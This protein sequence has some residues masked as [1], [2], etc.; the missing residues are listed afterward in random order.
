MLEFIKNFLEIIDQNVLSAVATLFSLAT[1]L[2]TTIPILVKTRKK[3]MDKELLR[4]I[5]EINKDLV[6]KGHDIVALPMR[7]TFEQF[8]TTSSVVWNSK[9]SLKIKL[10]STQK[11]EQK[12]KEKAVIIS[13]L[14]LSQKLKNIYKSYVALLIA[15]VIALFLPFIPTIASVLTIILTILVFLYQQVLGYRVKN[16][17]FGSNAYEAQELLEFLVKNQDK[18]DGN[19]NGFFNEENLN[20]IALDMSKLIGKMEASR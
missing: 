20:E 2:L 11:K 12:E 4:K 14:F 17:L 13:T 7:K 19:G 9:K 3:E 16:G 10:K 8:A 6:G 15:N 5:Y 18:I 1:L